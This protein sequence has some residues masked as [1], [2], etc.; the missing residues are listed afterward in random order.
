VNFSLRDRSATLESR[1]E[2]F[3]HSPLS[4][5][6]TTGLPDTLI[7]THVPTARRT[8]RECDFNFLFRYD[9]FPPAI[10]KFFGEWQLHNRTMQVGDTIVQQ[11]QVPPG[12][13]LYL[14]FAVRVLAVFRDEKQAGF[15]YGTLRGHPETGMN[16]FSISSVPSG[17]DATVRTIAAPGLKLSRLL[18]P[19]FTRRYVAFCNRQASER[20]SREFLNANGGP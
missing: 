11:A 12:W 2:E 16:A 18:A 10:L 3:R 5:E 20:M 7:R 17:I 6:T 1:L 15:S 13:G 19:I 9:I 8:L 14:V 4:Y